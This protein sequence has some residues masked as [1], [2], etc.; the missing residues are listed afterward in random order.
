MFE[1]LEQTRETADEYLSGLDASFSAHT[2]FAELKATPI[3]RSTGKLRPAQSPIL[4]PRLPTIGGFSHYTSL[5]GLMSYSVDFIAV[6]RKSASY[7]GRILKGARPADLPVEQA[8][9]F[10]LR[11]NLKTAKAIGLEVSPNLLARADEVIE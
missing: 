9:D 1:L 8:T 2:R 4:R 5:D 7:V 3:Y 10:T 11:I 6:G